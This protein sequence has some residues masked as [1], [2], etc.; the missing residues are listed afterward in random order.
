MNDGMSRP[1]VRQTSSAPWLVVGLLLLVLGAG[2]WGV[3]M[4]LAPEKGTWRAVGVVEAVGQDFV[5]IRHDAVA[6]VLEGRRTAFFVASNGLLEG[7]RPGDR[8]R[9]VAKSPPN[10]RVLVGLERRR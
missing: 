8:V 4:L 2:V 10:E 7:V 9:F 1:P 6:G 5:V 3:L